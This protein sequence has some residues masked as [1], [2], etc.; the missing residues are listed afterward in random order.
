MA[1]PFI[2]IQVGAVS[3]VDEGVE[4][5]LDTF[6]ELTHVN[7]L[8]LATPTWT[9]GTGGR[10]L[11]N[12]PLPDHG[13][14]EYDLDWRGGSYAAI[15][16][17]FYE[18]TSI[19]TDFRA[20]EHG[21][22]DVFEAV[23]PEAKKRGMQ[24]FAWMEESSYAQALRDLPNFPKCLEWNVHR[25]PIRTPCFNNPDY[26]YWWLGIVEDYCKSYDIDGV[27]G[28]SER[29]GPLA[30][31]LQGAVSADSLVCFC[32]HCYEKG[33]KRGIDPE[34]ARQ[35]Y[36]KLLEWNRAASSNNPQSAIRNPQFSDGFFISLWRIFL[37]YP[38]VF[39]WHKLWSDSQHDNCR[40]IYG[41]AKAVGKKI[42]WHIMHQ[43]SF[44]PF[45]RADEDFREYA[46]FSDF[47]KVVIYNN[48]AGPRYH[49]FHHNLHK[50][51]W[52]DAEPEE[53]LKLMYRILGYDEAPLNDLP[54]VGF[55]ADYVYRET[56]RAVTA[57]QGTNCQIYPG[58]DIDIPTAPEH[59]KCTREGVKG[60]V[61]AALRGGATGVILS[62]KY[63][64][65]HLDNLAGAGDAVAEWNENIRK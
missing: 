65:M 57:V 54:K 14:Q 23:I 38:E 39:A 29:S 13:V 5:V 58:I 44:S 24:S 3:F 48:C 52:A 28:C 56:Q 17:Q 31:V 45:Y 4:K 22:W 47:L 20:K 40:Q 12:H 16:P 27:I 51:L 53:T 46:T 35:G 64:E 43:V 62:R 59:T 63:S 34:R 36:L 30:R 49:N 25:V 21:D 7:A 18:H 32:P 41:V 15:H 61:L 10:Q 42:G 55:S 9:R 26:L 19:S 6:Q 11:P 60:A 33:Q 1:E 50:A 8:S 37:E 2:G